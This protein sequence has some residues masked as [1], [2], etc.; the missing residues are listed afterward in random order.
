MKIQR[1]FKFKRQWAEHTSESN[2]NFFK[3]MDM[4]FAKFPKINEHLKEQKT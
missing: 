2:G 1:N 4:K 3:Q